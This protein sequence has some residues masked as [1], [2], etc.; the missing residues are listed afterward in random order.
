VVRPHG[1]TGE[2]VVQLFSDRTERLAVGSTLS[3]DAGELR[4]EG[5]RPHQ[6]R[7]LVRF[8]GVSDRTAAD[9]LRGLELRAAPLQVEG[10]LWVHDLV[11]AHVVTEAGR[12]LGTVVALEPNPASDLLVLAGG[13]LVPL[14]F[15]TELEPGVRVTVDIP[16]GLVD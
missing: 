10:A 6:D 3:S 15:V 2:V 13:E 12:D 1:L 8:E 7:Y 11:G 16:D 4:V 14:R 5:A 9:A